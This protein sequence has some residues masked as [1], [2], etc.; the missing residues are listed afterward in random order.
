MKPLLLTA[1]LAL[2]SLP[3]AAPLQEPDTQ[4]SGVRFDGQEI[5]VEPG[6]SLLDLVRALAPLAKRSITI[7]RDM[8]TLLEQIRVGV[9]PALRA[10][11]SHAAEILESLLF[12]HDVISIPPAAPYL[13]WTIANRRK[14][15]PELR[16][17]A[18][19]VSMDEIASFAARPI[20][21]STVVPLARTSAQ[22]TVLNLRPVFANG[23]LE[24]AVA[25][26]PSTVLLV[27]Y[28]PNVAR[29][30]GLVRDADA[31]AGEAAAR[32]EPR[33]KQLQD[34]IDEIGARVR[35]L[36][37]RVAPAAK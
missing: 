27:G 6:T 25:L 36:E 22:E 14:A 3:R 24:T 23:N 17:A 18:M 10:P 32:V 31:K 7:P 9:E 33:M 35:E 12:Q 11:A 8:Q 21:V 13:S 19:R 15:D 1:A 16:A 5:T 34:R 29:A 26:D 37:K 2:L 4:T 20:L 28:G 30:A